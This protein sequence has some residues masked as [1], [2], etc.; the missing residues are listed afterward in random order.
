MGGCKISV[1][2]WVKVTINHKAGCWTK[3][4]DFG[5]LEAYHNQAQGL[6]FIKKTIEFHG[7]FL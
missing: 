2:L 4:V 3:T 1:E 5:A 6:H 7:L